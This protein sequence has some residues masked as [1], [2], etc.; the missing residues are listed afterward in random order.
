MSS[1]FSAFYT[2]LKSKEGAPTRR[3]L[4]QFVKDYVRPINR[5]NA[6][7]RDDQSELVQNLMSQ[8]VKAFNF[9]FEPGSELE[10]AKHSE[11]VENCVCKNLYS[12]LLEAGFTPES[13]EATSNRRLEA[14]IET[15]AGFIMPSHLEVNASRLSR[16]RL[17]QAVA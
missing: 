3:L 16:E 8:M 14:K 5:I 15:L 12:D 13:E 6:R 4:E 2:K 10:A 1:G 7:S 9:A 11:G 17:E